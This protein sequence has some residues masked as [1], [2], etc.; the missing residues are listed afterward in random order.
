MI[1]LNHILLASLIRFSIYIIF[2]TFQVKE[3]S[4]IKI[5]S[6]GITLLVLLEIMEAA[7]ERSIHGSSILIPRAIL[8]YTSCESKF[9]E[10]YF[11]RTAMIK[12]SLDEFTPLA[13]RLGSQNFV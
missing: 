10:V 3:I 13:L 8:A 4:Q 12:S 2:F 11:Q 9:I 7:K 6:F 5:V 1:F